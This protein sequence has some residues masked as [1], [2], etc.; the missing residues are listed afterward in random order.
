MIEIRS[1]RRVFELERRIY[2][3]DRLRLNPNGVPLR[4][5]AYLVV[6][7][8]LVGVLAHVPPLSELLALLPWYARYLGLPAAA[9]ALLAMIRVEGRTFHV[10]ALAVA[11][12]LIEPSVLVSFRGVPKPVGRWGPAEV[13]LIPDGSEGRARTMRYAGPGL[14]VVRGAGSGGHVMDVGEG[15]RVRLGRHPVSGAP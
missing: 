11:R 1:Y 7:A 10:A 15:A 6:A 3:I 13:I 12:R 14:A 5:I 2:R 4:G 8:A 9:A